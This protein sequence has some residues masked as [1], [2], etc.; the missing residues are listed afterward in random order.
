M[1]KT[2]IL[3][4]I[5]T[6]LFAAVMLLSGI[7][8]I[9]V[10]PESVDLLTKLGYPTYIIPFLGLAKF[11]GAIAILIPGFPRLKEWAYAGLF[12][13]LLGA[14][15]SGIMVEGLQPPLAGMLIFFGLEALSYIY[16]HK[17]QRQ[18]QGIKVKTPSAALA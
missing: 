17:R 6:G 7:Q 9:L 12:F 11:V 14:T 1:K 5:F 2:N 13:D 10:T 8:N 15:Y 3:Y 16:Y 18:L 4:W